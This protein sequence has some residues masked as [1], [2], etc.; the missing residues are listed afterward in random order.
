MVSS[1]RVGSVTNKKM[2]LASIDG[3]SL[4]YSIY[5]L[6]DQPETVHGKSINFTF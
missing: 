5:H 2:V 3:D 1:S 4:K 6:N